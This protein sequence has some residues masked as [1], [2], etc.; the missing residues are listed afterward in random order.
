MKEKYR[1]SGGKDE[2][3][4]EGRRGVARVSRDIEMMRQR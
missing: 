1:V 2:E 4:E 3:L